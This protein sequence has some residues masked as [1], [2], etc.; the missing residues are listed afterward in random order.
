M[1]DRWVSGKRSGLI[2]ETTLAVQ[3]KARRIRTGCARVVGHD[4][5]I[6]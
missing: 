4:A 2:E 3:L 1:G 5:R 6:S